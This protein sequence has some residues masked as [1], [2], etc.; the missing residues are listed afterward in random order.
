MK[1]SRSNDDVCA[2]RSVTEDYKSSVDFTFSKTFF[3]EKVLN[4]NI[5]IYFK[6]EI[7]AMRALYTLLPIA[8]FVTVSGFFAMG[9][10]AIKSRDAGVTSTNLSV[11]ASPEMKVGPNAS[12]R[13]MPRSGRRDRI[14]RVSPSA[15][16]NG[17]QPAEDDG[18]AIM[19]AVKKCN[20]GGHV[21]LDAP[22][23]TVTSPLDLTSLDHIDIEIAGELRFGN[24]VEYWAKHA[25]KYPFQ[26]SYSYMRIGGRN[27]NI[28]GNGT[29][30]GNGP[31][32]YKAWGAAPDATPRPL[33]MTFDGITGA[34]M[35]GLHLVNA[36]M[37]F[38]FVRG[39]KY[40][41]FS[42][43][44]IRAEN[45]SGI[46]AKNTDGWDIYQSDNIVIQNSVIENGDGATNLC[47]VV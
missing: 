27:V 32:F 12:F 29:V 24:S 3:P 43:L 16:R 34:T 10:E 22:S 36:P 7:P 13:P 23:Y 9:R 19:A 8:Y 26:D 44:H 39:A 35:S 33:I 14:C 38:I 5:S 47:R 18:P 20:R 2:K 25:F 4:S 42:D 1:S 28:F 41:V 45:G 21:L 40:V 11:I 6:P 30:D 15:P 17:G 37:W 31:Q 46:A